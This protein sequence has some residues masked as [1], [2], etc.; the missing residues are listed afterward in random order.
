MQK[1]EEKIQIEEKLFEEDNE[2]EG[3]TSL[4]Q[5]RCWREVTQEHRKK[6]DKW[7]ESMI[8]SFESFLFT[9][10][11]LQQH[12]KSFRHVPPKEKK[13]FLYHLLGLTWFDA[14]KTKVEEEV[15]AAKHSEKW[16]LEKMGDPQS[17]RTWRDERDR[18]QHL[19]KQMEESLV[20][21]E[22][23]I[24]EREEEL[25]SVSSF[26]MSVILPFQN[27]EGEKEE[28][29]IRTLEEWSMRWS[30][31]QEQKREAEREWETGRMIMMQR[32]H[33]FPRDMF[34]SPFE[35]AVEGEDEEEKEKNLLS[36]FHQ[37]LEDHCRHWREWDSPSSHLIASVSAMLPEEWVAEWYSTQMIR[38]ETS[39]SVFEK[40][41]K[42]QLEY[43]GREKELRSELATIL[44]WRERERELLPSSLL[45]REEYASF[46]DQGKDRAW[47]EEY[48]ALRQ[49]QTLEME[50][51][52][53]EYGRTEVLRRKWEHFQKQYFQYELCKEKYHIYRE[54]GRKLD[55]MQFN[56]ACDAC[57]ANPYYKERQ[58]LR[59][60]L[61][62][63]FHELQF[64][65]TRCFLANKEEE[66]KGSSDGNFNIEDYENGNLTKDDDDSILSRLLKQNETEY[67]IQQKKVHQLQREG[68]AIKKRLRV[69]KTMLSRWEASRRFFREEEIRKTMRDLERSREE[70]PSLK[71]A[72]ECTETISDW[73]WIQ[74]IKSWIDQFRTMPSMES[75]DAANSQWMRWQEHR[76]QYEQWRTSTC[77]Q[78]EVQERRTRL[79]TQETCLLHRKQ[80]LEER[81][82]QQTEYNILSQI[83]SSLRQEWKTDCE[84]VMQLRFQI[85]EI[86]NR[87]EEWDQWKTQEEDTRC[88]RIR[89]EKLLCCIDRDGLPFYYLQSYLPCMEKDV[90]EMLAPFLGKGMF[91]RCIGKDVVVGLSS[92]IKG[93][94]DGGHYHLHHST[95]MGG[96]ESFM[97][98][99]SLKI[100]FAKYGKMPLANFFFIDEGIS[101]L[102]Q[103]RLQSI[104]TLFHFLTSIVPHV[105]LITHIPSIGDYVPQSLH[106]EKI[107]HRSRLTLC[108]SS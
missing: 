90:N 37:S 95:M 8:G 91:L 65:K 20:Q 99:L 75:E 72:R 49:K 40:A 108:T 52:E 87:M 10:L 46:R 71:K 9:H 47:N 64:Q 73:K 70:D 54:N 84:S 78:H 96:M 27:E 107:D 17:A 58:H 48:E 33:R 51:L 4:S 32:K 102:D 43:D 16:F 34:L 1:Q 76:S 12:E 6:T 24:Q 36:S 11:Y 67:Q 39:A 44:S 41:S 18:L 45:S 55:T 82:R 61:E 19:L 29:E 103:D 62:S 105:F 38:W 2:K 30:A 100:V 23:T 94:D 21:K 77:K 106:V 66:N 22:A 93:N 69:L 28:E 15:R 89:M 50:T 26:S 59:S 88:R 57:R 35:D 97:C 98:D 86:T 104:Q 60:E 92:S 101:V 63:C 83:L 5:R 74:W 81:E 7:I 3:E 53:R 13:E 56:E 80:E 85:Q 25:M 42:V 31:L 79:Q 14:Y 68:D